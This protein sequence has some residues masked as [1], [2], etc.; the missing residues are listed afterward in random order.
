MGKRS[1]SGSSGSARESFLPDFCEP[2]STIGALV[3]IELLAIMLTIPSL[4]TTLYWNKL[5]FTSIYIQWITLIC[6]IIFCLLRNRLKSVSQN[7][8]ASISYA[9]IIFVTLFMSEAA[10]EMTRYTN[11]QLLPFPFGH[12]EFILISLVISAITGLVALRYFYLRHETSSTLE[13]ESNARLIAL[14]AR[15]KPH[16]LF[17]CMNTILSLIRADPKLAEKMLENL[18]ELMRTGLSDVNMLVPF[19]EELALTNRYIEME[20]LRFGDRLKV[21]CNVSEIPENSPVPSL[22]LQ[23][24]IENAIYHGIEPIPKGGTISIDG[25]YD[26]NLIHLQITNPVADDSEITYRRK[27]HHIAMENVTQRL[28]KHFGKMAALKSHKKDRQYIVELYIPFIQ[29]AER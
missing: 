12:A 13:A 27:G 18:A 9:I 10:F 25:R 29:E 8:Q 16:F 11:H 20:K 23:P 7:T 26:K 4:G 21:E 24:L 28:L 3:I 5:L 14:Q 1:H 2:K 6:L 17:N 22:S 19:S 15:I